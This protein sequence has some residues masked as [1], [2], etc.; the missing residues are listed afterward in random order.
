MCSIHYKLFTNWCNLRWKKFQLLF[1]LAYCRQVT[2]VNKVRTRHLSSV[3]L[4]DIFWKIKVVSVVDLDKRSRFLLNILLKS[5]NFI[6][7]N[8]RWNGFPWN[9]YVQSDGSISQF[10]VFYLFFN[11]LYFQY[12]FFLLGKKVVGGM[13]PCAPSPVPST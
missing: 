5:C 9:H 12:Y 7:L 8:L 3:V 13:P 6:P 10:H 2:Y 4:V 1:I 11:L